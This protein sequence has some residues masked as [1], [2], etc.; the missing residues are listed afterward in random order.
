MAREWFAAWFD[1]PYYHTL[2][3]R[4]DEQEARFFIDQLLKTLALPPGARILDLACGRGRHARY[5]AEKGFDVT[6]LDISESSIAYARSFENDRLAFYQHDMRQPFR[7]NYFDAV[8]NLFTSF[9]YFDTDA[10]HERA[11]HNVHTGL[12]P[13]GLFL[14][15]FFNAYWVRRHLVR[16]EEKT[17]N[18]TVFHLKKSIR[19]GRVYKRVEFEANGRAYFFRERVR[20]FDLNDFQ[21]MFKR[22]GLHLQQTYGG[23]DL[24]PFNAETS[25]RLILIAQK[26][27]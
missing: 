7:V 11:L 24:S 16:R 2:Y 22:V 25:E 4:R 3:Q 21:A 27:A 15:D 13:G 9:G 1:S 18:G 17:V 10:E 19:S 14:L 5:L 26:P 20:L 23:Y 6:G 8:L 12:K